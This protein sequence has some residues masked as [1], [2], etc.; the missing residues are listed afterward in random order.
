MS[1]YHA[2]ALKNADIFTVMGSIYAEVARY[3]SAIASNKI[4]QAKQAIVRA[5]ELV[6]YS[7]QLKQINRA[8]KLEIQKFYVVFLQ[9]TQKFKMSNL[10]NYLLPF[11]LASRRR[12]A[13]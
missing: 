6:E 11:A 3:D 8:Q 4:D 5:N 2:D 1:S 9:R 12:L 7:Q 13:V 10:D